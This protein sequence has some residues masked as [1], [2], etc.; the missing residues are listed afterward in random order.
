MQFTRST[1]HPSNPLKCAF[2]NVSNPLFCALLYSYKASFSFDDLLNNSTVTGEFRPPFLCMTEQVAPDVQWRFN[3]LDLCIS[4]FQLDPSIWCN[5]SSNWN[6][7]RRPFIWCFQTP[8]LVHACLYFSND[9]R[10]DPI[11]RLRFNLLIRKHISVCRSDSKDQKF[12]LLT[13]W[14]ACAPRAV[15]TRSCRQ[16]SSP[17][18]ISRGLWAQKKGS[19][20]TYPGGYLHN[21]RGMTAQKKGSDS[22]ETLAQLSF[23]AA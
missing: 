19:I 11:E 7:V 10:V 20:C 12:R 9:Q 5:D 21:P 14:T 1:N 18:H 23:H 17:L 4:E 13:F 15:S 6:E 8:H 22:L 3:P 16:L 2:E